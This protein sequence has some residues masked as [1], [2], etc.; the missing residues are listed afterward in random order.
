MSYPLFETR[1]GDKLTH[2]KQRFR[3]WPLVSKEKHGVRRTT[4]QGLV[5]D[6]RSMIILNS[7]SS[8]KPVPSHPLPWHSTAPSPI[9][10]HPIPSHR[11]ASNGT[12]S[13]TVQSHPIPSYTISILSYPIHSNSMAAN[14]VS[15]CRYAL[16]LLADT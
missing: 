14:L 2:K 3:H 10:S 6:G 9:P 13:N 1:E 8:D 12:P 4:M 7:P 16:T 15:Y 11:T 5:R